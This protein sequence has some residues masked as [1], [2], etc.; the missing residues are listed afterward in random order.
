MKKRILLY[1]SIL[2]GSL[3]IGF[4]SFYII[5]ALVYRSGFTY[6][7]WINGIYCTNKSIAEV[8]NELVKL[9]PYKDITVSSNMFDD[10]TVYLSDVNFK[11]DYTKAL[12]NLQNNQDPFKWY[13]N[14]SSDYINSYIVPEITFDSYLLTKAVSDLD[15]FDYYNPNNDYRIEVVYTDSGY[16]LVDERRI[17]LV[18]TDVYFLFEEALYDNT[19]VFIDDSYFTGY[20]INHSQLEQLKLWRKVSDAIEPRF[21]ID[22]GAEVVEVDSKLLSDFLVTENGEF[23]FDENKQLIYSDEKILSFAEDLLTPYNTY[24]KARD[25]VTFAG[26]PKHLE[27]T[28]YGTEIDVE[29]EKTYILNAIK[30]KISEIHIPTYKHTA[31][32]RGLNDIGPEFIEV[33]LT[34]QKLY[35]VNDGA[36][37]L[38]TDVVT[39]NPRAGSATPEGVCFIY[40]KVQHAVLVGENYRSPVDYWMAINGAIGLHDSSWQRAYGGDRYLTYGS[41]G[42]VNIPYDAVSA[43]Y[44]MVEVG[45]PV[46]VYK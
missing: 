15:I 32:F 31:Y 39:G 30:N 12:I 6:G 28:L 10:E 33:D 41:H 16:D 17:C 22:L 2:F 24:G 3:I 1:C 46:I 9:Y 34:N 19:D 13:K 4:A 18:Y 26:E 43:L 35:Y 25:Y 8:N 11:V 36:I 44:D 23:V 20:I 37:K 27:M 29:K 5:V 21:T 14:L 38:E 45:I 40:K 42:C 7:T